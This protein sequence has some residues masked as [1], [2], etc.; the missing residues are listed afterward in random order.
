M[1]V[2]SKQERQDR[3]ATLI[4]SRGTMRVEELQAEI[5]VSA[6]TLYRDLAELEARHVITRGRGEVS[7][8]ATSL[9][10]TSFEF[11][12]GQEVAA[13]QALAG[14]A[15][16]V[17][18]RGDS[19]FVDDSST[20]WFA[21]EQMLAATETT[22]VTNCLGAVERAME[23]GETDV[24][25][26]GGRLAPR[27][28]AFYGPSAVASLRRLQVDVALLGA[29]AVRGGRMFHPYEEVAD[30]KREVIDRSGRSVL[31]V[32]ASKFSRTALYEV[33]PLREVDL[34][35]TDLPLEDPQL[36]A[37]LDAG[38]EV[39]GPSAQQGT[40]EQQG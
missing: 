3:M 23:T 20:A 2:D 8:A 40:Q 15:A 9:S 31:L 6:M 26:V 10:E 13:K 33:A 28:Q 7:A 5:G 22:I 24:I 1:S 16:A 25:M 11:R 38:V 12:L 30:F 17:V 19:V 14:P 21:M 29:A 36:Q 37:A 34:I 32:T 4:F 39:L 35:V 18:Q 27:L